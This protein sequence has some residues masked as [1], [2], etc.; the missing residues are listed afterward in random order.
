[1]ILHRQS[2]PKIN[3]TSSSHTIHFQQ[4]F[5]KQLCS[6]LTDKYKN[7]NLVRIKRISKIIAI[8]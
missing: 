8:Y 6:Q 1:M 4:M 3:L 5:R 2:F 7:E